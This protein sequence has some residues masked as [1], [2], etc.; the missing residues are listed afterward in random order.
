MHDAITPFLTMFTALARRD[1]GQARHGDTRRKHGGYL[2]SAA[3]AVTVDSRGAS[4]V[5]CITRPIG[6]S[7]RQGENV[8]HVTCGGPVHLAQQ[9]LRLLLRTAAAKAGGDSN[10]L[11]A[12][13][14]E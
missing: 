12:V 8:E 14:T 4:N 1:L 3:T 11:L 9:R 10:I 13:Q 2:A 7:I 6:A 5:L